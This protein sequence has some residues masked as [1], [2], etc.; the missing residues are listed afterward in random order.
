MKKKIAL[1]LAAA[2]TVSML[3]VSTAFAASLN[4]MT[5]NVAAVPQYTVYFEQGLNNG[6]SQPLTDSANS[7][8]VYGIDGTSLAVN[9]SVG[10]LNA[11]DRIRISL[12]NAMFYFRNVNAGATYNNASLTQLIDVNQQSVING[13]STATGSGPMVSANLLNDP[14]ILAAATSPLVPTATVRYDNTTDFSAVNAGVPWVNNNAGVNAPAITST[15]NTALGVY[16]PNRNGAI[17][18]TYVRLDGQGVAGTNGLIANEVPYRLD[19]DQTNSDTQAYLTVLATTDPTTGALITQYNPAMT[20]PNQAG[21]QVLVP[22]VAYTNVAGDIKVGIDN[23]NITAIS[24]TPGMLIGTSQSGAT[25]T[26]TSVQT[27]KYNFTFGT[28]NINEVRLNSINSGGNGPFTFQLSLPTGFHFNLPSVDSSGN[29]LSS[30][31]GAV[32]LLATGGLMTSG[33]VNGPV[34]I[35]SIAYP[36]DFSNTPDDT[37]LNITYQGNPSTPDPTGVNASMN[38]YA[39]LRSSR[40]NGALVVTNISVWADDNL[41]VGSYNMSISDVSGNTGITGQAFAAINLTNWTMNFVT[42]T[43]LPTLIT[44]RYNPDQTGWNSSSQFGQLLGMA[45][46]DDATHRTADV[47]LS[48]N[49]VA[50][51][52]AARDTTFTLPTGVKFRKVVISA[53]DNLTASAPA[54]NGAN[55]Y[56]QFTTMDGNNTFGISSP[57]QFN[58]AG[59]TAGMFLNDGGRPHGPVSLTDSTFTLR[60]LQI[61]TNTMADITLEIWVS[62]AVGYT[63]DVTLALDGAAIPYQTSDTTQKMPPLPIAH[64]VQPIT[65]TTT[66]TDLKIG[67]QY[68]QTADVQI[69]ET[70]PGMLQTGKDLRISLTDLVS[71]DDIIFTPD[72]TLTVTNGDLM[73]RNVSTSTVGGATQGM[74]ATEGDNLTNGTSFVSA[75]IARSSSVASTITMSNVAVKVNR[76]VPYTNNTPYQVVVWGTSVAENF[77]V[78]NDEFPSIQDAGIMQPYVTVVSSANDSASVLSQEVSVTKGSSYYTVN[79]QQV[80]MDAAAYISPA[81]NSM[82]VP[83][84]FV[85]NAFGI[86]DDQILWDDSKKAVTIVAPNKTLQFTS[87]SDIMNINGVP[88]TMM[89]MDTP[90]LPVKAEIQNSRMY[91]PFRPLGQAFGV[92]VDWDDST[93]I[94]RA[95]V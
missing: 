41:Q 86:A 44:G 93:Q 94:G 56:Y 21:W 74:L 2:M 19:I 29:V 26:V 18:G 8:T 81:S 90:P 35:L 91:I 15:Y 85:A 40:I 58:N 80:S 60:G 28:I 11:G 10:T 36:N 14:T 25:N 57:S 77:G 75:I 16:V 48:E 3:P 76:D 24:S 17:T 82:M 65:V 54:L 49:A 67:Y 38:P 20:L 73:L 68:Q 47:K 66:N 45:N 7:N 9:L 34:Q 39:L 70:A 1:L 37:K 13:N 92:T 30:D 43:A 42:T 88:T 89:S 4:S 31:S 59:G 46:A 27:G 23:N 52:W 95:H 64:T 55:S 6:M 79:G 53:L 71:S 72:T 51:W 32:Q 62:I 69:T 61:D 5:G 63:G 83:I 33:G 84:R 22:I 12:T 78:S 87:N 50:S